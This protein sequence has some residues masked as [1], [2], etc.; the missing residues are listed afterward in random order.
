MFS[1]TVQYCLRLLIYLDRFGG[2]IVSVLATS[3]IDREFDPRSGQ[4]KDFKM[5]WPK[6]N[7]DISTRRE[8]RFSKEKK[9]GF[10]NNLFSEKSKDTEA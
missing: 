1:F 10:Q 5:C 2:E 8:V 3:I 6:A 7:P 4:T 9:I